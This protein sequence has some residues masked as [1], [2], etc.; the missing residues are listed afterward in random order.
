[1]KQ[2]YIILDDDFE[3]I[4]RTQSFFDGFPDY[5]LAGTANNQK[6][7]INLILQ[8]KPELVFI[9]IA[10]KNKNCDLSL[11]LINQVSQLTKIT[12][13]YVALS[14]DKSMGFE[15]IKNEIFDYLIKPIDLDE[16]RKTLHRFEKTTRF[17]SKKLCVKSHGDYRFLPIDEVAYCKADNSSTDIFLSN[18]EMFTAFK[19]LKYFEQNLPSEFLRI[20]NSFVVNMNYIT[21]I[22]ITSSNCYLGSKTKLPISKHY[23]RN[24]DLIINKLSNSESNGVLEN[25]VALAI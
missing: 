13:K 15:A 16:L 4:L 12:P 23:K 20:H 7:A 24:I 3:N 25:L 6:D 19:T 11:D 18:G 14:F 2:T 9:E 22:N 21:R 8:T 17:K 5:E 10:S 1:M